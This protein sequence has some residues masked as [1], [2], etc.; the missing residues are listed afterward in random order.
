M[1]FT[2][3]LVLLGLLA[4]PGLF[5]LLR[6]TPPAARRVLF[7]PLALLRGLAV[8]ER[9]PRSMPWWLLLLRLLA[10]ALLII[11]M[12]GPSLHPPPALPGTGPV[13]LVV[14]NGWASAVNWNA[15]REAGLSVIAAAERAGRGVALLATARNAANQGPHVT[16]VLN[17]AAARQ[18]MQGLQPEPWPV[19]R[20]GAA[21]ALKSVPGWIRIYIADGIT[22]GPGF[23]AFISALHPDRS[24][25]DGVT[26]RL[27]LP[28]TLSANGQ[29]VAHLAAGPPGSAVLAE[30]Q[31]GGVLARAAIAANG[32]ALIDLPLAVSARVARLVLDGPASAGGTVL[33]DGAAHAA[34]VGL[35]AGSSDAEAAYLG[36]LFFVRQA[37][38]PGTQLVTGDVRRLISDK[39]GAIVLADSP[40]DAAQIAAL[41]G[42]IARGG[43]L[44]RFAGPLTAD[45]PD[46]LSPDPLL[47]GDRRL[48]GALTW[49]SPQHL[50]P[51]G[52]TPA[53]ATPVGATPFAGLAIDPAITVARQIL[54]DPT[55]LD[56]GTVWASLQD[57]TPLVL[58]RAMGSGFLVSVLTTANADWSNLA[59]SGLFPA[60]LARLVNLSH[61]APPRLNQALPAMT[62]LDAFGGLAPA[63]APGRITIAGLAGTQI[64]P[65]HPPGLYGSGGAVAAL[66]IGGHVPAL[67][68][69][70]LP[71]AAPL[72][73]AAPPVD[74]GAA[75]IALA[76]L[77][78][79]LDLL[80]SLWLR[81]LVRMKVLAAALLLL[82]PNA[83]AQDA[84]LSTT[85]AYVITGNSAADGISSDGLSYLSAMVSA[86]S[87][88]QLAA[89]VGV[90]PGVDDL[91]LYP[92]I[93]WPVLAGSAPPSEA[94]CT[95]LA[96]YM[97]YGGLLAIDT[98]GGDANAAGSG[99]GFAPGAAAAFRAA[100]AC[101]NLP[102]LQ[103]LTPDNVLAHCFYIVQDFPGKFDG[104]PVLLATPAARDADGV[105]P[106]IIT[107]NDW[108][109]AWARDAAGNTEQMPIPGGDEQRQ[110]ADWF[111]TNLVI[112]ALT[113]S[114]KADQANLTGLLD[115]L[116]Q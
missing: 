12:A 59:L 20:A 91:S 116:G 62:V 105:T 102:P 30:T 21:K 25:S 75:L 41:Q 72:T 85:L 74:F 76:I 45:V 113:G 13:L 3:P 35:A 19:D 11:G 94:A 95:A 87:S 104:A 2:A 79:A 86:H 18:V 80:I 6:L 8:E 61:G 84:A 90:R 32:G 42:W 43:V 50:A 114:Y 53:G 58:G 46:S 1:I 16:G 64:S 78:L 47:A 68:A 51:F 106:V 99:A 63:S 81:G 71:G 110:V 82:A 65:L 115:R 108:A 37:L 107:Q 100:T 55:Q 101:L 103:P 96:N 112:Y 44:I 60:M 57:G 109:A 31:A 88:A 67:V 7:P 89:P 27:L 23:R 10:A 39:A 15:S 93:Y 26:A 17:A 48:G 77:L 56:A 36:A 69:A 70:D 22:D 33:L 83:R 5:F 28:P 14:D 52:A 4:L 49:T 38:P 66:N 98:E 29:M 24:L 9:T 92:L 54:A 34:L 73:G 111:G 40:L 97:R